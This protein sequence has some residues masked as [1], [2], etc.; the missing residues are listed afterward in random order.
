MR[1]R[2]QAVQIGFILLLGFAVISL[3]AFQAFIVPNQNATVE[4]NH[5][6]EV[7]SDMTDLYTELVTLGASSRAGQVLVP[8][9]IGHR[10][11]SRLLFINPPPVSGTI[12]STSQESLSIDVAGANTTNVCGGTST[13]GVKYRPDYHESTQPEITYENGLL[14]VTTTDGEYAILRQRPIVNTSSRTISLYRTSGTLRPQSTVS[15]LPIEITGTATYGEQNL[16]VADS[17]GV[18]LP[19]DLPASEWNSRVLPAGIT[20]TQNGNN[21]NLSGFGGRNYTIR[22][23]TA[24]LG[25]RPN[26]TFKYSESF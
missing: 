12:Q 10:Y 24:G 20:A 3:S 6:Q 8:I 17:N 7:R 23:Y 15:T 26:T 9:S 13:S 2:A 14:Y 11:P 22:C 18:V 16:S 5:Y 4:F 19:S 21:V 1:D 25:K